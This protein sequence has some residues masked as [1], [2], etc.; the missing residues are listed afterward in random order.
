MFEYNNIKKEILRL[1]KGQKLYKVLIFGSYAYGKTHNESDIDL[2]V[3]LDKRGVSS[4]YKKLLENKKIISK[5]LRE[6]RKSIP[7]DLL[8]Y[9]KE[10]WDILRDSKNS[11][12]KHIEKE[13]INLIS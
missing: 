7:I 4:S 5:Q 9:T 1:L 8:V 3:I 12:V 10:E 13:S 6:L 2:L 11:F